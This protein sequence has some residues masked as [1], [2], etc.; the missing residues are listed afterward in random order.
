MAADRDARKFRHSMSFNHSTKEGI[1]SPPGGEHRRT[2]FEGEVEASS[3]R[4][5]LVI[6]TSFQSNEPSLESHGCGGSTIADAHLG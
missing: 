1:L 3:V 5:L 6:V 2:S 4:F